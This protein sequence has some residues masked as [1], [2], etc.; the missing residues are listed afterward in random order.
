MTAHVGKGN[1]PSLLVGMQTCAAAMEIK[2]S[3]LQKIG[4]QSTSRGRYTTFGHIPKGCSFPSQGYLLS[5]V[6]VA[7]FIIVRK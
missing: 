5:Y 6:H 4:N 2:M 3:V 1:M 7:L